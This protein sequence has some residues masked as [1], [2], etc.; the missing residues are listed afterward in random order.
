MLGESLE[1]CAASGYLVP[2]AEH[3]PAAGDRLWFTEE[4]FLGRYLGKAE[5]EFFPRSIEFP[6]DDKLAFASILESSGSDPVPFCSLDGD[7]SEL[8]FPVV[9]KCRH[10]WIE[11]EQV[12][13]GGICKS[14]EELAARI[15]EFRDAGISREAFFLQAYIADGV[16][17]SYS[18]AGFF[19]CDDIESSLLLTTRKRASNRNALGYSL[20]VETAQGNQAIEQCAAQVLSSLRYTGPFELEFL[21]DATTDK[22]YALELNPRF[23]LQHSLF[24]HV[25]D[26]ALVKRY[27]NKDNSYQPDLMQPATWISG[28]GLLLGILK[29]WSAESH[30]IRRSLVTAI[31]NR[32]RIVVDPP[33]TTSLR[34]LTHELLHRWRKTQHG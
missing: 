17:N 24:V 3:E 31:R 2:S 16:S 18:V 29:P 20:V 14:P 28:I 10:S 4:H 21:H 27:V 23:W 13:R 34:I 8:P 33:V 12:P 22:Y 25:Y 1:S 19:D 32:R 9:L 7:G 11:G 5:F 15:S 6:L 30:E 26:N